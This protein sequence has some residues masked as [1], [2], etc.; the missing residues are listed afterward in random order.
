MYDSGSAVGEIDCLKCGGFCLNL[1]LMKFWFRMVSR[2]SAV[3]R[4]VVAALSFLLPLSL[5]ADRSP[6]HLY[7]EQ[8]SGIAVSEMY[9]SGVPASITLAQGMLESSNGQSRL[10]VKGNN[11]FGIKCH[12]WKGARM[13]EDDDRKGEC[14]RKYGSPEESFRDHS[15]FLRY[16]DRYSF[17]FDLETTDY[18]GWAYGLKRAGYATDPAYPRKLI[19][20]IEDYDLDRFDRMDESYAAGQEGAAKKTRRRGR[21]YSSVPA[22]PSSLEQ[23]VEVTGGQVFSISLSRRLYSKNNVVFV[24]SNEGETYGDI[25][26]ANGLFRKE[27]LRFNDLEGDR[28]LLPGTVVYL[29][30]KKSQ[31][32]KGLDKHIVDG[33]DETLW[34]ISQRYGVRMKS[35]LKMNGLEEDAVLRDGDVIRLR[36]R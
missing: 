24:Y 1:H 34:E 2:F 22:S 3:P 14:F 29:E 11:H 8:Y 33:G 5:S 7:I 10:A 30:K 4:I 20:L 27:L 17:L 6:Q 36:R 25:A 26:A 12:D 13:F 28:E 23:A 19:K 15:D 35:L 32:V 9:R 21:D 18:K 16:R 31:A